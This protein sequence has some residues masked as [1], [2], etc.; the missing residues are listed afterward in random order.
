MSGLN[1]T[2]PF[3][4]PTAL[5]SD[6]Y[7]L[8]FLAKNTTSNYTIST[9]A[10]Y[11][12]VPYRYDTRN[13]KVFYPNDAGMYNCRKKA[14][15][16][17]GLGLFNSTHLG[18]NINLSSN[19]FGNLNNYDPAIKID[20]YIITSWN[21][22]TS[23]SNYTYVGWTTFENPNVY[24]DLKGN[25]AQS[26]IWNSSINP[27]FQWPSPFTNTIAGFTNNLPKTGIFLEFSINNN[28]NKPIF[29]IDEFNN[30][31]SPD[32]N[33]QVRKSTG[34]QKGFYPTFPSL[35]YNTGQYALL[36]AN[37]NGTIS[38]TITAQD[39]LQFTSQFSY[40]PTL[41]VDQTLFFFLG[42]WM[43]G[44]D[45]IKCTIKYNTFYDVQG[46]Y[47]QSGGQTLSA[48]VIEQANGATMKNISTF[49]GTNTL[50]TSVNELIL[51][52]SQIYLSKPNLANNSMIK[53]V[54]NTSY[55]NY[56]STLIPMA[57]ESATAGTDYLIPT[58]ITASGTSCTITS[59]T[60]GTITG[61]TCI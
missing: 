61:A 18:C 16:S 59:I 11:G 57:I 24:V 2:Y 12:I 53:L 22:N 31:Y 5:L 47:T 51:Q 29:Q 4:I 7:Y 15:D 49:S 35:T 50:L 60:N 56:S 9:L 58:P 14:G 28:A 40:C 6:N 10:Y 42:M 43:S 27:N 38:P 44:T 3:K 1:N 25:D 48:K 13:N 30:F 19:M 33:F 20:G 34:T 45:R 55:A 17:F 32:L 54:L 21:Y 52:G 37:D 46:Y 26:F 8:F 41:Q 23:N 39:G 36:S